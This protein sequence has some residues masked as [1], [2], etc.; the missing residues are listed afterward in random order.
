MPVHVRHFSVGADK[1]HRRRFFGDYPEQLTLI[2][3]IQPG[4][5]R[6]L[7]HRDFPRCESFGTSL[8]RYAKYA[9]IALLDNRTLIIIIDALYNFNTFLLKSAGARRHPEIPGSGSWQCAE[10]A[11]L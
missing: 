6:S 3:P 4:H 5:W 8:Y 11:A 10:N 2:S 9:V 1:N 7:I